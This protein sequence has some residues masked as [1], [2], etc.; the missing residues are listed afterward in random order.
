[1]KLLL[2]ISARVVALLWAAFWLLFFVVESIAPDVPVRVMLGWI[3]AGS[4]FL[5][6]ALAPWWRERMG[7]F[8]LVGAGVI[9]WFAYT[10]WGPVQLTA[11]MRATTTMIFAAPPVVAGV[12]FLVHSRA[13]P[14]HA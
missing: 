3:G 6:L 4:A 2:E 7:G 1:M 8:L 12:L 14:H 11:A 13:R 9:L 10:A 5:L